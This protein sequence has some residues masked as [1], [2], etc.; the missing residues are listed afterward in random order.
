[1]PC[2]M[3]WKDKEFGVPGRLIEKVQKQGW[4]KYLALWESSV[5]KIVKMVRW[6]TG[7]HARL[8]CYVT[9]RRAETQEHGNHVYPG[10]TQTTYHH[11]ML[12]FDSSAR[13]IRALE[14]FRRIDSMYCFRRKTNVRRSAR[15]RK[16]SFPLQPL[17]QRRGEKSTN[18]L[19]SKY[20]N[21]RRRR[22]LSRGTR[23]R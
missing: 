11:Y 14:S 21:V 1:M 9:E 2:K 23:A 10:Q 13:S 6:W 18:S 17:Q 22:R 12:L 5:A 16:E 19:P 8:L 7:V 3:P 20:V 15:A 4:R